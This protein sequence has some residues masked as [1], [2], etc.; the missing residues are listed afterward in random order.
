MLG[1][2]DGA[3]LGARFDGSTELVTIGV[4]PLKSKSSPSNTLP[5]GS[6]DSTTG[7][8]ADAEALGR[9]GV[10]EP[11]APGTI[12]ALQ[13]GHFGQAVTKDVPH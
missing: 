13:I 4:S 12:S 7:E 6:L 9:L 10:L 2:G 1:G 5:G 11:P 3:G 8:D